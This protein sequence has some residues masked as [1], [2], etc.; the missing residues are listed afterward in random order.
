MARFTTRT[1]SQGGQ[2][3]TARV[4]ALVEW[5]PVPLGIGTDYVQGREGY[6]AHD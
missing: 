3:G 4:L 2:A 5:V 1:F 6:E